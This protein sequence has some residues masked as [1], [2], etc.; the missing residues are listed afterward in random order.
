[1]PDTVITEINLLV[2]E[3]EAKQGR[4]V[5]ASYI[6]AMLV[7]EATGHVACKSCYGLIPKGIY[8]TPPE[9][10]E[11]NKS[12]WNKIK[13]A[14][15]ASCSWYNKYKDVTE[16]IKVSVE[17]QKPNIVNASIGTDK[18]ARES[19]TEIDGLEN[20]KESMNADG[21]Q[22]TLKV[23]TRGVP[24][25]T[26]L[27]NP[28]EDRLHPSIKS[29]NLGAIRRGGKPPAVREDEKGRDSNDALPGFL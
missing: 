22:T 17:S 6:I 25:G 15:T 2:D 18:V 9:N 14:H 7:A 13:K 1:M 16:D 5:H 23:E 27:T 10:N 8:P 20:K 21:E 19:T 11:A 24:E 29:K 12:I 26:D 3:E 28:I 4:K